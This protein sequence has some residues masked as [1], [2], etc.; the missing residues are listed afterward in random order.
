[1]G[2]PGL[3]CRV[4]IGPSQDLSSWP[5]SFLKSSWQHAREHQTCNCITAF[6]P[7]LS[8]GGT[9]KP[10]FGASFPC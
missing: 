3:G 1:M 5:D 6:S 2:V 8:P 7:G 4:W 10:A 9:E